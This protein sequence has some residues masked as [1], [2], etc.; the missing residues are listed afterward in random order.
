MEKRAA[1]EGVVMM[2]ASTPRAAKS[3]AISTV[4]IR[5]PCDMKGKKKMCSF[6]CSLAISQI[7]DENEMVR[8]LNEVGKSRQ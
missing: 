3:L 4:G 6:W 1:F 2:V 8:F 5:W 7:S